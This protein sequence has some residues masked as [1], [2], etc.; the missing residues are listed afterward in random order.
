MGRFT[1]KLWLGMLSA[2]LLL[3][4]SLLVWSVVVGGFLLG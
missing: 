1:S 4:V 3:L 2:A